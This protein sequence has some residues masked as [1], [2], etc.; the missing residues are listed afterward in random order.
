L[1][2]TYSIRP[3]RLS[4]DCLSKAIQPLDALA[5]VMMQA[6]CKIS[7]FTK[8][9]PSQPLIDW[10]ADQSDDDYRQ[11]ERLQRHQDIQSTEEFHVIRVRQDT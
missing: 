9:A 2:L 3:A 10:M 1:R 6:P 8:P 11:R 4:S 7:N 5:R